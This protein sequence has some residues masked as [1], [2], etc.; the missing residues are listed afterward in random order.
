MLEA[1]WNRVGDMPGLMPRLFTAA[2]IALLSGLMIELALLSWQLVPR[3]PATA[4][5]SLAPDAPPP[6]TAA[7]R[8]ETRPTASRNLARW[9]LFGQARKERP[10][11]RPTVRRTLP[12]TRLNLSLRGV[13]SSDG[14][15][16][17]GAII[18]AGQGQEVYYPVGSRLPGGARLQSVHKDHVVLERNGRLETLKLPRSGLR[19]PSGRLPAPRTRPMNPP[20]APSGGLARLRRQILDDPQQLL[21]V[22]SVEPYTR[23]GRFVGYR[24][25]PGRDHALF[26]L[27]GLQDGD[28]VTTINGIRLDTP[29]RAM[30]A[31]RGLAQV[32]EATI[33]VLRRGREQTLQV[34]LAR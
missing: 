31:L 1:L 18:D 26:A 2:R 32:S 4:S 9:H 8:E 28:I 7:G 17:G 24:L 29:A 23:R 20:P 15:R 11:P 33:T 5:L 12:E 34:N 6:L 21:N 13:V 22:F 19:A 3:P 14:G 10:A 30:S 25:R 27:T 16:S